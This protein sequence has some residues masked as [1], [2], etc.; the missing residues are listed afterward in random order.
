MGLV[1][2]N[3]GWILLVLVTSNQG[4]ENYLGSFFII[5]PNAYKKK[6]VKIKRKEN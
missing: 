3:L 2:L 5:S 4:Q 6:T 1:T